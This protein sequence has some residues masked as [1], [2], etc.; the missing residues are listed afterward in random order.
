MGIEVTFI[1]DI[2]PEKVEK[3]IK[4]NTKAVFTESIGNPKGDVCDLESIAEVSHAYGVPFIVDNTFSPLICRP[5]EHGVDVVIHSCT[6]WICG[7]GTLIGGVIVDSGN[8]DWT[9]GRFPEFTMPDP[10]YHGIVYWDAFGNFLDMGNIAYITKARVQGMRNIGM[11]QTPFNSFLL[12]QGLEDLPLRIQQHCSNAMELAMWLKE[13]ERVT[14]VNY[15]G[16]PEN[17]YHKEAKKY[18]KRGFGAVLGFGI[19]GGRKA[20]KKFIDSLKLAKHVANV[21]D[22]RTLVIHPSSTTHQQL[23]DEAQIAAGLN[24]EFIRVSVGL[25]NIDDIKADFDQALSASFSSF[26]DIEKQS[27]QLAGVIQ[28]EFSNF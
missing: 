5:I 17:P 12:L 1:E 22:A 15:T 13:H 6:K 20:G 7:H 21:G 9:S 11:C 23:S 25:E 8:F 10:S 16:L 28:P 18:L 2:T 4:P 19:S 24:P 3:S 26:K 27:A 14:W